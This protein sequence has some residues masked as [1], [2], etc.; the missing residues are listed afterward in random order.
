MTSIT[1]IVCCNFRVGSAC[2]TIHVMIKIGIMG[3]AGS[4]SEEA[5]EQYLQREGLV[6]A[7]L[8]PLVTAVGVFRALTDKTIDRALF[9][10][11]NNIAGF[12]VT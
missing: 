9:P 2:G 11:M 4:F 8:V 12:L 5:G 10:I 6:A 1:V 3:A 7:E